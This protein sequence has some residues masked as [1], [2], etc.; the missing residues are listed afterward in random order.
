MFLFGRRNEPSSVPQ[1]TSA[2]SAAA[3]AP[4]APIKQIP[5]DDVLNDIGDGWF[6]TRLTWVCG[7]GFSAAAVEVVLTGFAFTE[8]RQVWNLTEYQLSMIPMLVGIGSIV[9]ELLWGP[10][11]D[12]IGR[13]YVFVLT[14]FL[15]VI[16]GIASA[17]APNIW[18]F[19]ILRTMVGFGYGGNIS[20]DFALFSE[21]L[22]LESRGVRLFQMGLFWPV[23]QIICCL[24]AKFVIPPFG[25]RWFVGVCTVPVAITACL[26]PFFPESPRWLLLHQR[27]EEATEICRQ[28]AI[29]N[30]VN[31]ED[32]GLV[33]GAE[34]SLEVEA[35]QPQT[36]GRSMLSLK[37]LFEGPLLVTTIGAILFTVS[38]NGAGYGAQTLMPTLLQRKGIDKAEVYTTMI[39]NTLFQIPGIFMAGGLAVFIGRII[40]FRLS[41]MGVFLSLCGFAFTRSQAGVLATTSACSL[42]LE[43][44]WSLMHVYLPEVYPTELRATAIGANS[45]ISS[46]ITFGVPMVAAHVLTMDQQAGG[47]AWGTIVF[48]AVFS[49]FGV[50]GAFVCINVET[51]DR[52]L[53]DR[54]SK[55]KI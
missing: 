26:R 55:Q 54:M 14:T 23:G 41:L 40:P 17:L 34:V 11:A 50:I 9:G 21:F 37:R 30:G 10:I 47:G 31:P 8:L 46:I 32:V 1:G 44:G 5:L 19:A 42:F 24:L 20:V 25:W 36:F 45:A 35:L 43:A 6:Q 13:A 49:I 12:Y 16:F 51:K 2:A 28:V 53:E 7:L 18:W 15:V 27:P 38:L 29:L 39:V 52:Y 3:K 4:E 22:P 33:A 48:F